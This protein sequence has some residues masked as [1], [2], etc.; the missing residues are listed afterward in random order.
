MKVLA[1]KLVEKTVNVY[2]CDFCG[3]ELVKSFISVG[4]IEKSTVDERVLGSAGKDFFTICTTCKEHST[5]EFRS[6]KEE[7]K[8]RII[9]STIEII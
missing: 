4:F 7:T 3:C 9:N 1:K 5:K 6:K 8:K 2:H